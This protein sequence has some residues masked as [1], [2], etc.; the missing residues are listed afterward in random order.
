MVHRFI[1]IFY[2]DVL[3]I[4]NDALNVSLGM[5]GSLKKRKTIGR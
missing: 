4:I 2:S 3:Y 5:F 1:D